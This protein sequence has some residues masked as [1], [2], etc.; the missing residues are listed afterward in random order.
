MSYDEL[1][2][3][4][5]ASSKIIEVMLRNST[6][7]QG[8]TG[9]EAADLT[10]YYTREGGTAVQI[11][12]IDGSPGDS[13]DSGTIAEIHSANAKG[14][15]QLH[16]P[17]AALITGANAVTVNIQGATIIDKPVKILLLDADLRDGVAAVATEVTAASGA[18]QASLAAYSAALAVAAIGG[19][20]DLSV[21][22]MILALHV[23]S[24]GSYTYDAAGRCTGAVKTFDDGTVINVTIAYDASG[25]YDSYE[26]AEA[27]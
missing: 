9:L 27:P 2:V 11:A 7:G 15:Y 19:L 5:A 22:D 21:T 17:N 25:Q 10:A 23:L 1:I 4:A 6:T 24:I 8:E 13:Y 14:L 3:K 18:Y 26:E 16:I 12:L 20:N